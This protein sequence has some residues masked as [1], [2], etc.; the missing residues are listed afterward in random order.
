[1][2]TSPR[3][4]LTLS[5][6]SLPRLSKHFLSPDTVTWSSPGRPWPEPPFLKKTQG[7]A[8]TGSQMVDLRDLGMGVL[9]CTGSCLIIDLHS[10]MLSDS[11]STG[12]SGTR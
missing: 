5:K 1:M 11:L 6:E 12:T 7:H 8:A 4:P 10:R 9:A 2:I 3:F